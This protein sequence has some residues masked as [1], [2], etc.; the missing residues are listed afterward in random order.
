MVTDSF[1]KSGELHPDL[2]S[3]T[4]R[5]WEVLRAL[6]KG[7]AYKQIA[8]EHFVSLHTVRTQVRTI[9]RKLQ[10]N[11]RTEALNKLHGREQ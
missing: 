9:Y 1:R 4:E 3:L 10:V 7:L 6:D 2:E 5:E 8:A 11:T